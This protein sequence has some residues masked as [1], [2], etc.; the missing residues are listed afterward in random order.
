M[1]TY[2]M[3]DNHFVKVCLAAVFAVGL[4]T[5]CSSSSDAPADPPAASAYDTAK[6]AIASATTADAARAA[7]ATAVAAG[8]T[9]EQLQSLNMAVDARITALATMGRADMQR[10]A[11]MTA[12][13]NIDTSDLSTQALVDAARTAIAA[14]KQAIAAAVDVDD[15]SMY[16]TQVD[17]AETAVADAQGDLDH[18]SQTA[19]LDEAVTGLQAID[20]TDLSTQAKI[21]AANTAITAVRDALAAATELSAAEKTA[22]M[23]EL[24][25]ANRTVMMAQGRFDTAAQKAGLDEAVATLAALDLNSLMTQDEIDAADR[26]I[27]ALEL[28]LAAAT[29]LTDAE[30]LDATVDVTLA[31]RRVM[32]AQDILDTN[33]GNQRT[34]LMNAGNALAAL[35]LDDLDTQEKIDAADEAVDALEMALN[36]ATHLSDSEKASYQTQLNE[37]TEDVRMAQTGMDRDGRMTAQRTAITNAVT[38]ARTA[39]GDVDD[40]STD[41]EVASAD[42][43]IAALKKAIEDAEDLPEGNAYVARAQGTLAALEPQLAA[44]KTSRTAALDKADR[45]ANVKLG[46]DMYAALEGGLFNIA[47]M[48][49]HT[50]DSHLSEAGLLIDAAAG[51]GSLPAGTNPDPVRLPAGDSAGSLGDWAGKHYV[52]TAATS[53]VITGI[54][55]EAVVYTNREAPTSKGFTEVY[56]DATEY[57]TSTRTYDVGDAADAK[58]KSSGFPTAGTKTFAAGEHTIAGTYHGAAGDYKCTA[59]D[60]AACTAK[61]NNNGSITLSAPWTFVHD[62]GAMVSVPDKT[63]LYFGHWMS[64]DKDGVPT[65]GSAF[66]GSVP[67]GVGLVVTRPGSLSGTATYSGGAA[68]LFAINN[69]GDPLDPDSGSGNGGSFTA[70]V[71]LEAGFGTVQVA[72]DQ[73]GVK[74]TI[75]NFRLNGGSE[76]PGWNVELPLLRWG[77]GDP[78]EAVTVSALPAGEP[79]MPLWSIDGATATK[80]GAG[81]WNARG[82]DEKP[83]AAPAGDGSDLPTAIMGEFFTTYGSVGRMVGAF[84][85]EKDPE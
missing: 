72:T 52:H 15:T 56:G 78:G 41:D 26:A 32:A 3:F 85:T 64:R 50:Q 40:D 24:A 23:T 75:D 19:A 31:K 4:L 46:K 48:S 68:G 82:Y 35:D 7:V 69:P 25:T 33:V 63:Y 8:I 17:A 47:Y 11:L 39:V 29:N 16:Q 27:A 30:K 83:G 1:S 61:Y 57:T 59:T 70:D 53:N 79:T 34:A 6:A 28:A 5:A 13:G 20:L 77:G 38:M 18:D 9:G 12:A 45:T 81:S 76:D 67:A 42:A 66:Y 37:A 73:I 60:T 62:H 54:T 74:G 55:N 80:T 36:A 2:R 44:A 10:T 14:L 71:R 22:A 51:A 84:G 49:A 58:I 43:A 21:D 65:A